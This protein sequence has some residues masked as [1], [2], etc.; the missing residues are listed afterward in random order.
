M[1]MSHSSNDKNKCYIIARHYNVLVG[2]VTAS[3][4]NN[5]CIYEITIE[6][7]YQ[8]CGVENK[9]LAALCMEI[10]AKNPHADSSTLKFYKKTT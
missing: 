5:N 9:L 1:L 8:N 2:T 4:E 7:N 3:L 10:K 6:K